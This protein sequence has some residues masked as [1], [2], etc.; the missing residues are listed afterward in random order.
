[1]TWF[2]YGAGAIGGVVGARLSLA[3]EAVALVARGDHLRA[4]QDVGLT[5]VD[6]QGSRVVPLRAS[7]SLAELS[8]QPGD[9]IVLTVKTQHTAAALDDIAANAPGGVRIL[10]MQNGIDNERQALRYF[11]EVYGVAVTLLASFTEPGTVVAHSAPTVGILQIGLAAGGADAATEAIARSLRNAGLRVDVSADVMRYKHLKLIRNLGN[12]IEIVCS[13]P[14]P[15]VVDRMTAEAEGA[16][17]AAGLPL[18]A[19]DEVVPGPEPV[20]PAT[21]RLGGS[22]LQ[23]LLRDAGSVETDYLNGEVTLL[24]RLHGV[25]T[26]ANALLQRLA[27]ETANGRRPQRSLTEADLLALLDNGR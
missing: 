2:I 8:P 14:A 1:M 6:P 11:D 13:G 16:L 7:A 25:P 17:A 12:A 23:S 18:P 15:A 5:L 24:G 20:Q 4:I 27:R 19:A 3:G 9:T 26:P 10:C 22:T 21:P